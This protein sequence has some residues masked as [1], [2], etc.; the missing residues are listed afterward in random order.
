M[1]HDHQPDDLALALAWL[2]DAGYASGSPTEQV[3]SHTALTKVFLDRY[4][5][6]TS[7]ASDPVDHGDGLFPSDA[8]LVAAHEWLGHVWP[9]GAPPPWW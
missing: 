9:V 2:H 1:S 7:T 6:G 5:P 8:D 4:L 3:R